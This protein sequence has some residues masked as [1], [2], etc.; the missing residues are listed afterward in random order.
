MSSDSPVLHSQT[1][2]SIETEMKR[3]YLDY[4]MSVIVSRALPDCRDGLKPVHRRILYAMHEMNNY[5][6]KPYKKSARVVGD[7]I[8]KYHPHGNDPIYMA[9]VRMAQEFSLRVPL[10]DGQGNFG[11][12]DG[13]MPAAMRYTE[14]RLAK[15]STAMLKDIDQNTVEFQDNY[16]GSEHEPKVLPARFPNLLVN[17]TNGIAVGMATNIPSHNLGE[18]LDACC[19]YIKNPEITMEEVL[20]LVPAPDFPT[21]GIILGGQRAK[22]ALATGRGSILVRG[23]VDIEEIGGKS[24]IIIKEIPYQVNKAD[25]LQNIERLSREKIIEGIGEMRDESNKLG[26]RMVVELKKG[27]VPD[28]ILNQ[29]YKYTSLQTSFGVNMLALNK[30]RP[31]QMN[32]RDVI[33][34][35]IDFRVEVVTNRTMYL[36]NK[37]RDKAH[38]LIGLSLAVA[39]IDEVIAIIRGSADPAEARTKL[40]DKFWEAE[41]VIPLLELVDDY[42]NELDGSKC[43]FT[44]EQATAILE[45]KLQKLTGLEKDKIDAE[46]KN[47]AV[48]IKEYLDIL[49][50]REKLMALIES[51][52]TEIKEKYATPRRT[53]IELDDSGM[54]M[55]DLIQKEEMIVTTTMSGFIKRVPLATYKAQRRGGKGRSA[56]TTHDDDATI[57]IISTNTHSQLLFFSDAGK[58]Y[59]LKVYKL[60]LGGPQSKGRALVNLL[61]IAQDEKITNITK[62][63]DNIEEWDNFSIM[64]ATSKGNVR[65]N[66]LSAFENINANGK[67]AIRLDEN[68]KLVAVKICEHSDHV[69][70]STSN[71]KALRFATEAIRVF[72]SR[73][74][75]GV[76]GIKLAKANDSLVSM[77]VLADSRISME[78][79][80][81]Y[82]K[83]PVALRAKFKTD[84]KRESI[85]QEIRTAQPDISLSDEE[86]ESLAMGE[87]FILT[88]SDRGYGKRSSS[89]EYRPAGRGGQ[90]ITNM[91][92]NSK[93]G[94]VVTSMPVDE[95]D[96]IIL[97]TDSGKIIRT[98]VDSIRIT[99]R[100][101]LGVKVF[102]ITGNE[103]VISVTKVANLDDSIEESVSSDEQQE[104]EA[105]EGNEE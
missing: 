76:R 29:I 44:Y 49:G 19:E 39:N 36:L 72:K 87:E 59:R 6:D 83:L 7:V 43:K 88:I 99:G 26:I 91:S 22:I 2:V 78:K 52:L 18:V 4:A 42:R 35:F 1:P 54:D 17:G 67:I 12:I 100:S 16:D 82:L 56:M 34:A 38:T 60:P 86:I 102:N 55:E 57:D 89:Y 80:E 61:P 63:P 50:S 24:A 46:L 20:R 97:L 15:I 85:L 3:S 74:S 71:G 73:T 28:V 77:T 68:D 94:L 31:Q 79:R 70:L 25:L 90:G 21:G 45:M 95:D 66:S 64:F 69:M 62:L 41:T 23:K 51:E 30:G 53:S 92:L 65:R 5:H 75:D 84:V 9:L 58:V 8:G 14:A 81:E 32:V 13:D 93:N 105:E 48:S 37:A 27:F 98:Q 101:A 10:I 33:V 47:L 96:Q 11:S 103:K 104:S 40:M